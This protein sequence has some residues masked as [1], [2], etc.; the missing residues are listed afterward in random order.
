MLNRTPVV[1]EAHASDLHAVADVLATA[2]DADPLMRFIVP[3]D[4]YRRR[5]ATLFAF[6]AALSPAWV[7]VD[8]G[9]VTGAALWAPPGHRPSPLALLRHSPKVVR[10]FGSRMLTA[11]R[12]FRIVEQAHPKTPPHWYLQTLGA[13]EQGRGIGGALLRD[14]LAR[15]DAAGLPAYLESSAP[16][17]VPIYERYG[18]RVTGEIALPGGPSLVPMWREPVGASD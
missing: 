16:G 13:A 9:R 18:F 8:D 4:G 10:T 6:E 15:V 3:A 17:N 14:G 5:V 1:R 7:A 11:A 12:L 2:F